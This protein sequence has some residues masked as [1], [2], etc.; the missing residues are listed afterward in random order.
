MTQVTATPA[1]SESLH[2][3]APEALGA[4]ATLFLYESTVGEVQRGNNSARLSW[5][6]ASERFDE[7]RVSFSGDGRIIAVGGD[8]G[9]Y[10]VVHRTD[11]MD[12][13]QI[14]QTIRIGP[15]VSVILVHHNLIAIVCTNRNDSYI[16]R[17]RY[18]F[19]KLPTTWRRRPIPVHLLRQFLQ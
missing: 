19:A 5:L 14:G 16:P 7:A 10:T 12:W 18:R 15:I 3:L 9:N 11:G 2:I 8:R 6:S 13:V 1:M 4:P 17:K